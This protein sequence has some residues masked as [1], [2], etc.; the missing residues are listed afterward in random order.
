MLACCRFWRDIWSSEPVYV[1][2]SPG[3]EF[4]IVHGRV[5]QL[6]RRSHKIIC[7]CNFR[8]PFV[9][10]LRVPLMQPERS[11]PSLG[12]REHTEEAS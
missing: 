4:V 10:K 7:R 8:K 9:P 2:R 11:E 5:Q 3:I 6:R 12:C 1:P